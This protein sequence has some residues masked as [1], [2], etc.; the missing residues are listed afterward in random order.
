MR[1]SR[2]TLLLILLVAAGLRFWGIGSGIPFSP[3]VDE[4]ELMERSVRMM[5]T[6]DFNPHFFD[7]PGLYIHLQMVVAVLRFLFGATVGE[8]GVLDR[9]HPRSTST[10][11]A[12]RSRRCSARPLC[13]CSTTSGCGG[14]RGT[15]R[16]ARDCSR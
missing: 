1:Q 14:G 16:L 4:P 7:Y 8:W 11:G 2:V 3:Q 5:R 10:C 12:G 9:G 15:P 6:G 13:L